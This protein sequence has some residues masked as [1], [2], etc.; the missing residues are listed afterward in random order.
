MAKGN[1]FEQSM[2]CKLVTDTIPVC[3]VEI[4]WLRQILEVVIRQEGQH[5][6]ASL[7]VKLPQYQSSQVVVFHRAMNQGYAVEKSS[8]SALAP[9]IGILPRQIDLD[10]G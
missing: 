6:K 9:S 4:Q 10:D 1:P 5:T 3:L 8:R 7:L 2:F